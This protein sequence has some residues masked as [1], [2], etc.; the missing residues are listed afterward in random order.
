MSKKP[1]FVL[2]VH[3]PD[4]ET[5][6]KPCHKTFHGGIVYVNQYGGFKTRSNNGR[7][8]YRKPFT[9]TTSPAGMKHN[10]NKPQ[11]YQILSDILNQWERGKRIFVMNKALYV[12]RLVAGQ[13]CRARDIFCTQVDHLDGDPTNNRADNLEWVTGSENIR[14]RIVQERFKKEHPDEWERQQFINK[15]KFH[16]YGKD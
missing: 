7:I 16:Y 8:S 14:R 2:D 3:Y 15:N 13:F 6:W 11:R 9:R 5:I 1:K 4:N 12:H 10:S